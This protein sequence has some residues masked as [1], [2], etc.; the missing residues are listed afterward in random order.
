[1]HLYHGKEL[2]K[3][4]YSETGRPYLV[5]TVT[6]QRQKIFEDFCLARLVVA[7]MRG[8]T[9]RGLV[10]TLA[11]VIMPDHVHWLIT[12][13]VSSLAVIVKTVKSRSAIAIN[14]RAGTSG[15][16]W[17][18]GYHDHAIRRDEDLAGVARYVVANPL[19][20]GLAERLGDYPHW[21]V[22]CL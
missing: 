7:E 16:V 5:T 9:D 11:W 13:R 21:D 8:V 10:D 14:K 20:A 15:P 18:S 1:M 12:L 3:S 19:R 6:R 2:R 4:R 22:F 17:Q